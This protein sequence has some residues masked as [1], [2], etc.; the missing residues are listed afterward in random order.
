[1]YEPSWLSVL[2][3]LVAIFTAIFSKQVFLSLFAGIWL[4]WI[5]LAGGNPIAG[6][7]DAI[8]ACVDVFKDE[9]NT[10]VIAFSAMVGS[11]VAFTQ[12][13][14]GVAGFV[15]WVT[16]RGYIQSRRGAQILAWLVGLGIFV[17]SSITCLV[18]GAIARPLFD[19]FRLSREKLAYLVDSTSAPVCIL[20]PMNGWGAF[21]MGLLAAQ[22]V[23]SPIRVLIATIPLNFYALLAVVYAL[24][25]AFSGRDWGPMARAER[26]ASETGKLLR[27]GAEPLVST[28]VLTLATK[29]GLTPRARNM[30]APIGL[31]L[32]M[33]PLGLWI[34]GKG[35]LMAGSGSTAVLWA[36]MAAT[37]LA[38]L[39][40]L[41]QRM[42]TLGELMDLFFKGLGG[43][44]PLALLMMFAFA[45]GAT[46][47][48]LE[49]GRYV[50]GL[51]QGLLS[52]AL[53][54]FILFWVSCFIAF[55]T[56]TS[57]GTFAIMLPIGVPM[58]TV[59]GAPLPLTVA[60]VLAGGVF[61][62][63][64][65]PISD[66]TIISSMAAGSDHID[67]VNTQL[68]YALAVAVVA[69]LLFLACGYLQT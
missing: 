48:K 34:T 53:V 64:C 45:I 8:Q 39:M 65:S 47:G 44:M 23:A 17:E 33:I 52:P 5:I 13:S 63:H 18:A 51:A 3:P 41:V 69:S 16:G 60:S 59:L 49:T 58:A 7:R 36:V 9:G 50:A 54:P 11:L 57:W 32:V 37:A 38:A 27:D 12:R 22:G 43:L 2:P 68:P 46:C 15:D 4:G 19:R 28:E 35:D 26:R 66:T 21:V 30:L 67:H 56:G 20:L 1:M 29:E 6:L 10:R 42:F 62:D 25:I 14:G 40:Y 61:G 31:M 55:A 24:Y